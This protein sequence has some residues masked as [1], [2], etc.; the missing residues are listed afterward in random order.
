MQ[1]GARHRPGP[2]EGL[3]GGR[4]RGIEGGGPRVASGERVLEKSSGPACEGT[5]VTERYEVEVA[6]K[7]I[8][9]FP[10]CADGRGCRS[11]AATPGATDRS[12][13][14]RSGEKNSGSW[15]TMPLRAREG[16]YGCR[17]IQAILERYGVRADGGTTRSIMRDQ[18]LRAAQPQA[19]AR[20]T[21]PAEDLDER[22]DLVRRD[23]TAQ[24][25]GR[26]WCRDIIYISTWIGFVYLATVSGCCTKKSS[27]LRDG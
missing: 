10:R 21:I 12:R 18:G 20:T 3:R 13:V 19:K 26:K 8:T 1:E 16:T 17:R 27:G 15:L 11:P 23:F 9:P 25:P 4:D 22:P 2:Q 7:A 5:S 14:P 6:K 24:A